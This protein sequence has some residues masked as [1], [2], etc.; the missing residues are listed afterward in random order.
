MD[1]SPFLGGFKGKLKGKPLCARGQLRH[2]H[3]IASNPCDAT[4]LPTTCS[5]AY[6]GQHVAIALL[7]AATHQLCAFGAGVQRTLPLASV[8]LDVL[9]YVENARAS[10]FSFKDPSPAFGGWRQQDNSLQCALVSEDSLVNTNKRS[11]FKHGVL[12]WC[13]KRIS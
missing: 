12:S 2:A 7:P 8:Q 3:G 1:C 11:S 5:A 4:N 6:C 13:E 9:F 10:S